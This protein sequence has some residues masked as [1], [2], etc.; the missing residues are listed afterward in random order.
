MG[1]NKTI[2]GAGQAMLKPN[3]KNK[4]RDKLKQLDHKTGLERKPKK[5][6]R[7]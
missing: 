4:K 6:Q 3:R 5:Q 7:K 1:L 2:R